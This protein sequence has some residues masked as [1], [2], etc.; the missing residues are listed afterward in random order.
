MIC[1][2]C[3][4]PMDA[5]HTSSTAI[6]PHWW[7]C[8]MCGKVVTGKDPEVELEEGPAVI[9]LQVE[10]DSEPA[11]DNMTWCADQI[12]ESDIRYIRADIA[13]DLSTWAAS[14]NWDG[15]QNTLEW[16]DGL[17][18]RINRVQELTGREP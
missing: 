11:G 7:F 2:Q 8:H 16:L 5:Q 13:R 12:E 1:P 18:D 9:F 17:R 3:G 10:Y 6:G 4:T 15:G 14:I